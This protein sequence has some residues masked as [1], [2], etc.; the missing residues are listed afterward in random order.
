MRDGSSIFILADRFDPVLKLKEALTEK[1]GLMAS[2][3]HLIFAGKLLWDELSLDFYKICAGS[4]IYLLSTNQ[5]RGHRQNAQDLCA[6]LAQLLDEL[7]AA[8]SGRYLDVIQEIYSIYTNPSVQSQARIDPNAQQ[9]LIRAR[10]TIIHSQRP[11]SRRTTAFLARAQDL[12]LYGCE[13]SGKGLRPAKSL[14]DDGDT[15]VTE[16]DSV[17][18][19]TNLQYRKRISS[20]PLP[21]AWIFKERISDSRLKAEGTEETWLSTPSDLPSAVDGGLSAESSQEFSHEVEALKG[22]GFDDE[23]IILDALAE[24]NGNVQLAAQLLGS[25]ECD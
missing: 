17:L 10:Q 18:S 13:A 5:S 7:L 23:I 4:Q 25:Y 1:L 11:I 8:D 20:Q 2:Q 19:V 15:L 3:Q 12:A 6:Q 22:M 21:N 14:I 9:L 16:E 24:T